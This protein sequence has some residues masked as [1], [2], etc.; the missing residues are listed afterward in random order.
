MS[1]PALPSERYTADAP[2]ALDMQRLRE[3][4]VSDLPE[5]DVRGR[6]KRFQYV[7]DCLTLDNSKDAA[8]LELRAWRTSPLFCKTQ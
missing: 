6:L 4:I 2:I 8:R 1:A 7:I 3:L 5:D